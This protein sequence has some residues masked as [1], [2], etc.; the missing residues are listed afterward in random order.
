[1][2]KSIELRDYIAIEQSK[3]LSKQMPALL[4]STS[5]VGFITVGALWSHFSKVTL[6]SWLMSVCILVICRWWTTRK[7]TQESATVENSKYRLKV[8][9]FWFVMNGFNW[10]SVAFLFHDPEAPIYSIYLICVL[11]G[12]IS[13]GAS[14][15]SLFLP[16]F[17]GF[18]VPASTLFFL[19]FITESGQL[20]TM[21]AVS[22]P[23][24]LF[25]MTAF[26]RVSLSNFKTTK[27]LE[28]DNERLLNEVTLQRNLAD[29]AV[30]EKNQFLAATSHDLRQPLHALGLYTDALRPRLSNDLNKEILEK[31]AQS[32]GALN[33]LLHG[34][35]D[36]SR[37]DASVVENRPQHF[38]LSQISTQLC[39][40]FDSQARQKGLI[41]ES[42]I[43]GDLVVNADPVL[44]E[45]V[46]RNLLSNAVKYTE[47]GFVKL[48]GEQIDKH[49]VITVADSGMGVAD[50]DIESI[51]SE[52][53]Q[54][55]NPERDRSKGLGL[56]L[57][58]VKRLRKLQS[59]PFKFESVQGE[60]SV[61]SLNVPI[62]DK[63]LR[64]L[65]R[66]RQESLTEQL[67]ILFVDDES[68]IRDGMKM[69]I[70]SWQCTPL[71]AS[72]K[73]QAMQAIQALD[74]DLDIIISDLRLRDDDTGVELIA[75][76]REEL[77]Q[78]VPA[79]IVTG[80]TA[81]NR[82]ELTKQ[83]NVVLMHKPLHPS[84][85]RDQIE[86]LLGVSD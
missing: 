14:S 69:L 13:V 55:G 73:Q 12:Y 72:G 81:V 21:L 46:L 10:G 43:S 25:V 47:D 64:V 78:D 6:L 23:F 71:I 34:L 74:D 68:D 56:G 53:T 61:V 76:I 45:R 35:L 24:Y 60:G 57:S 58:I 26:A 77:N 32:G 51:F 50:E 9:T 84:D 29:K 5:V 1:M 75:Q 79:I 37:L 42:D 62:G 30:V 33:D 59:I 28:F 38:F 15:T 70:S 66:P 4:I 49:I 3:A 86:Q 54:L 83:S 40:E 80:D 44:L 36:I 39:D 20:Y 18:A 31:I 22:T 41:L 85:L 11:T 2:N 82:L 27:K 17:F 16:A 19:R 67:T 65:N 8:F 7:F 52:F 48:S 63:A